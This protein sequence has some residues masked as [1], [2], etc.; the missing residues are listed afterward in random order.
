MA[1]ARRRRCG[2]LLLRE[3]EH[4]EERLHAVELEERVEPAAIVRRQSVQRAQQLEE[5]LR[6]DLAAQSLH[7][8]QDTADDCTLLLARRRGRCLVVRAAGEP[9][10]RAP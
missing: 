5:R 1:V 8:L 10:G 3:R 9:L 7:V 4:V 2:L 6:L